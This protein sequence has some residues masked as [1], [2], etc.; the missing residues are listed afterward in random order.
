MRIAPLLAGLLL[1][2]CGEDPR[3]ADVLA[4]EGDAVAGEALYAGN[5]V[6]CH[7]ADGSGASGPA[8]DHEHSQ[9]RCVTAMLNGPFSM[10][11]FADLEDQELADLLA[12]LIELGIAAP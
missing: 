9:E 7:A 2:G 8:I 12:H 11:S 4:L 3:V 6:V 5:C 1:V 10:P